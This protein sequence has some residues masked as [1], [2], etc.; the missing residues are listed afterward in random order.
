MRATDSQVAQLLLNTKLID[1]F[2]YQA[3]AER[4][5]R[6]GERFH[7]LVIE[8]GMVAEE[9]AMSSL[10]QVSNIPLVALEKM[11]VDP[12]AVAC[13]PGAF[14]KR[15]NAFPCALRDGGKTLWLAMADPLDEDAL[16]AA[17]QHFGAG[18]IRPLT[19]LP[20]E[21]GAYIQAYY[22]AELDAAASSPFGGAAIDLSMSPEEEEEEFKITDMSG[23]TLVKHRGELGAEAPPAAVPARAPARPAVPEPRAAGPEPMLD[24]RLERLERNQQK[25]ARIIR[26]L[27]GLL[28]EKG[29]FSQD[30]YH[31]K[32]K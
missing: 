22:G 12:R 7:L 32:V 5:A 4:Q 18:T 13:L 2:Q 21:I 1:Q 26:A 19:A 28:L 14:C 20:S 16:Q 29:F 27:M 6:T 23:H 9:R 25:A 8:L 31:A 15:H 11:K 24:Q 10:A 3:V 17:R 30:E